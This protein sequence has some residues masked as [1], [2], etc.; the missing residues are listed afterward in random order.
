MGF[1]IW[2][3][4]WWG[5]QSP[6]CWGSLPWWDAD[7]QWI[8]EPWSCLTSPS[9]PLLV[10]ASCKEIE[11]L[12]VQGSPHHGGDGTARRGSWGGVLPGKSAGRLPASYSNFFKIN[13]S[14]WK[15]EILMKRHYLMEIHFNLWPVVTAV[16]GPFPSAHG[17]A[18]VLLG[19][20]NLID[21]FVLLNGS[22]S[23]VALTQLMCS[24]DW[25]KTKQNR[26]PHH[27]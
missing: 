2:H 6:Q 13:R 8:P 11:N 22:L 7:R 19:Q 3:P 25:E 15:I 20:L 16:W 21:C 1:E 18:T 23:L 5:V 27:R 17:T 12:K 24:W 4:E 26:F 9:S 10:L 14:L